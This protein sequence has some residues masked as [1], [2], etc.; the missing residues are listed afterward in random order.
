MRSRVNI[1]LLV[2]ALSVS[3]FSLYATDA[4]ATEGATT[5]FTYEDTWSEPYAGVRYL[6]RRTSIPSVL[7]ALVVDLKAPGVEVFATPYADRWQPVSDFAKK[8]RCVAATNGGF[9]GMMQRAEGITAGGGQRWPDGDDDEEVGFFAITRQGQAWISPPEQVIENVAPERLRD[10]LSGEPMLVRDGKLD[11]KSLDAFSSSELR[12]P[13]TAIGVNKAGDKVIVIVADGRRTSSRGMTLYA[14]GRTFVDLG[15]F[16]ALNLD[17]G[18]SSTMFL[19]GHIVSSPSGGRWEARLGLG[20][21]EQKNTSKTRLNDA[22]VEEVFVRGVEREV[23]NHL[24][25]RALTHEELKGRKP[26]ESQGP[27]SEPD[28]DTEQSILRFGRLRE[29]IYPIA[30]TLLALTLVTGGVWALRRRKRHR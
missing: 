15:A 14:L 21:R 7:Y 3:F 24:C 30:L 12:H 16:S 2:L 10:A 6:V 4:R 5:P 11:E 28:K 20:V 18:G 27:P 8:N 1:Q 22:G 23:M 29:W 25:V 13:R 26:L 19:S 17:G 9:W